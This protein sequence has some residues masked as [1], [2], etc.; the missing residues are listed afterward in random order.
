MFVD[1]WYQWNVRWRLISMKCLLTVDINEMFVDDWYQWNVQWRL[2]SMKC[3]LTIGG[4]IS[5]LAYCGF[6][7]WWAQTKD[8]KI[9][10]YWFSANYRCTGLR[11]RIKH[12]LDYNQYNILSEVTSQLLD[13]FITVGFN[14]TVCLQFISMKYLLTIDINELFVD[15]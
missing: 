8:Y 11:N 9:G 15:N 14:D 5:M 2:I 10:I 1:D 7:P 4:V 12:W 6:C 13:Y 3:S